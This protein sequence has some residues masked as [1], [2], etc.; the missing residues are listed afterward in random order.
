MKDLRHVNI[1]CVNYLY[2]IFIKV[3]EYF[4]KIIGTKDLMVVPTNESK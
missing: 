1:H 2:F 4:E 3:G